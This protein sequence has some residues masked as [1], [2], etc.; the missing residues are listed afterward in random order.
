MVWCGN[1]FDSRTEL[2]FIESDTFNS[3]R[4]IDEILQK[5]VVVFA[6]FI[7]DHVMHDNARP[8][9]SRIVARYLEE[10]GLH[11]FQWQAR[12]S[13]LYPIDHWIY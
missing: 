3:R 13:D 1:S 8:N 2:L 11:F 12:S 9:K 5:H 6:Q 10:V 7:G 4:H